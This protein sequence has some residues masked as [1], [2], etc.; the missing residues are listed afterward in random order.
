M[1]MRFKELKIGF[2]DTTAREINMS[3][4]GRL[5]EQPSKTPIF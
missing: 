5:V 4:I 1:E 3:R 2:L